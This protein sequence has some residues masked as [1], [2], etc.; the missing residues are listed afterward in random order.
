MATYEYTL[1]AGITRT[2]GF[3]RKG[4]ASFAANVGVKC[5][6][7]CS[8]CSSRALLRRHPAFRK[9]GLSPFGLGYAIVDPSAPERIAHDAARMSTRGLIQVCTTVDA[10]A[11]EAQEHRLGRRVLEAILAQ[12]GWSVRI[13]TKNAAVA[14]D[15]DLLERHRDRVLVGLSLTMLPDKQRIAAAIET[16][17]TPILER[18]STL[19]EAHRRSLRTYGML[20]PLLPGIADDPGTIDAL[21]KFVAGCGAEELFVEPVNNRGDGLA[22]TQYMLE[23]YCCPVEARA[24]SRIRQSASWSR[25]ACEL[26]ANVQRAAR[27]HF[28]IKRLR[29]LLYPSRLARSELKRIRQ[30]PAGVVWLGKLP[31][32][33][34]SADV[35]VIRLSMPAA[36]CG[37]V[38]D[39]APSTDQPCPPSEPE[40]ML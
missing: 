2:K 38:G 34:V 35:G 39:A 22:K 17:A 23:E 40:Y 13:L 8:Y 9:L 37:R 33:R 14:A 26:L 5:G 32:G 11:P 19:Q 7:G 15:F 4:L 18:M 36:A 10:W 6:H 21:V 30:D 24:V 20:C 3:E 29:F 25:Y 16:H 12:P 31:T 27:K 1:K 28:D